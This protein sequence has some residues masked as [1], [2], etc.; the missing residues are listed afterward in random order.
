MRKPYRQRPE[1]GVSFTNQQLTVISLINDIHKASVTP[2]HI[3]HIHDSS[4]SVVSIGSSFA[5]KLLVEEIEAPSPPLQQDT[6]TKLTIQ[7]SW[8]VKNRP[9]KFFELM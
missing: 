1:H 5:R 3:S 8:V 7:E 9:G 4:A 6:S 2:S